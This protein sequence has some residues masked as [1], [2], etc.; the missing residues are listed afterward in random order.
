MIAIKRQSVTP[1]RLSQSEIY[2][3]VKNLLVEPVGNHN[4]QLLRGRSPLGSVEG[5]DFE[6]LGEFNSKCSFCESPVKSIEAGNLIC[7]RPRFSAT[8]WDDQGQL[9]ED[10]DH[11]YWLSWCWFNM[12]LS[13]SE[14]IRRVDEENF[15]V[16]GN[17]QAFT[18]ILIETF[19]KYMALHQ[20]EKPLIIDPSCDN[21]RDSIQIE[22][23]GFAVS[24]DEKGRRTIKVFNLNRDDLIENRK[25]IYS[26]TIYTLNSLSE[27][28]DNDSSD[29]PF[30][31]RMRNFERLFDF[32]EPY[33]ACRLDALDSWIGEVVEDLPVEFQRSFSKIYEKHQSVI[34][35]IKKTRDTTGGEDS[36]SSIES[37]EKEVLTASPDEPAGAT[38]FY[39]KEQ[40]HTV[41]SKKCTNTE[42]IDICFKLGIDYQSLEASEPKPLFSISLINHLSNRDELDKLVSLL[43]NDYPHILNFMEAI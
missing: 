22:K 34:Q 9:L 15:P 40:F 42:L 29:Y 4:H 3:N 26:D 39:S 6:L 38:N 19:T 21:P 28:F 24:K 36:M 31:D 33:L 17:R 16:E 11:Y 27:V 7:L 35:H 10:K 5:L 8:Q 43:E 23:S 18:S 25:I 20:L 1:Q 30:D 14:C 32:S 37:T 41:L 12:F 13:C 2:I